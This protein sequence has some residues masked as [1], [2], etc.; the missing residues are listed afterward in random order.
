VPTELIIYPDEWHVLETP[1][2]QQDRYERSIA[3]YDRFLKP[4][5]EPLQYVA[6]DLQV[7]GPRG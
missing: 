7:R 2:H 1:S 5:T 3:W 6:P 4:R